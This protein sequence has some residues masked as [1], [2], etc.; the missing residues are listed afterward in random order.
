MRWVNGGFYSTL[1]KM[2]VKIYEYLPSTLHSKTVIIDNWATVGSSNL[3]HRSLIH[4]LEVDVTLTDPSSMRSLHDHFLDDVK[5]SAQIEGKTW[6]RRSL[7]LHVLEWLLLKLK[8][9][10]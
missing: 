2:G 4:D 10:L 7:M 1:L 5:K 8:Y 9:W 3:N 6:G